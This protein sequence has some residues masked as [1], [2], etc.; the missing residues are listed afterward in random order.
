MQTPRKTRGNNVKIDSKKVIFSAV[1]ISNFLRSKFK[2]IWPPSSDSIGKRLKIAKNMLAYAKNCKNDIWNK[3][4]KNDK[5]IAEIKF[6]SGPA[7]KIKKSE[8]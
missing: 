8:L 4:Q 7:N 5:K 2:T 1:L 6:A 3:L